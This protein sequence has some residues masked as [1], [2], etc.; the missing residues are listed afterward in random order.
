MDAIIFGAL[1]EPRLQGQ[2][3]YRRIDEYFL[4]LGIPSEQHRN[5]RDVPYSGIQDLVNSERRRHVLD[6]TEIRK[7]VLPKLAEDPPFSL[8]IGLN[9]SMR[10]LLAGKSIS[11]PRRRIEFHDLAGSR[12]AIAPNFIHSLDAAHMTL[13]I[14]RMFEHNDTR[15]FFAV[16]D[17]FAV[18]A[19][20]VPS[21]RETVRQ[22]F[23]DLH[24]ERNLQQWLDELNPGHNFMLP[25]DGQF[26]LAEVLDA[27]YIIG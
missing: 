16:H 27:P 15:D 3:Q 1:H 7:H 10:T 17:C 11:P 2:S 5:L 4:L 19:C 21:L 25:D 14:N 26:D 22:S 12:R 20:D 24:E 6:N 9:M 13:T 18:H 8:R 23:H